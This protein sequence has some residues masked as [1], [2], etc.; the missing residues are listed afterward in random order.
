VL[1]HTAGFPCCRASYAPTARRRPRSLETRPAI[2]SP[3]PRVAGLKSAV[4]WPAVARVLTVPP[5][6]TTK[7]PLQ[8]HR[9][10]PVSQLAC[11]G[12]HVLEILELRRRLPSI[13]FS[14][15]AKKTHRAMTW[16]R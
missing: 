1:G 3:D 9:S 15:S 14:L 16:P 5:I 8:Y 12:M 11:L 6:S 4:A 13:L 2:S 10:H 7:S